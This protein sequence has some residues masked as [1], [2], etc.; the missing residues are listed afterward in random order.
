MS[1]V[2]QE[3]AALVATL[4]QVT[5]DLDASV[6][7]YVDAA[8]A[9]LGLSRSDADCLRTLLAAGSATPGQLVEA[10]GLTSGGMSGVIDR[11]ERLGFA[12]RDADPDDRR[13][14]LVRVAPDHLAA[15]S[16]LVSPWE[17]AVDD[18]GKTYDSAAL[19]LLVDSAQR[20]RAIFQQA[21]RSLGP[22]LDDATVSS[23]G[24]FSAPLDG[25]T[26][27]SLEI[28]GGSFVLQ[29]RPSPDA[30]ALFSGS[31]DDPAA[32]VSE[33]AGTV[34]VTSQSRGPGGPIS[35]TF[36]LNPRVP[37]SL[38]IGGGA[39]DVRGDLSALAVSEIAV[40]G[41][42]STVDLALGAPAQEVPVHI[43][44][45]A[46]R[47][48]L[49]PPRDIPLGVLLSGG[50]CEVRLDGQRIHLKRGTVWDAPQARPNVAGYRL[51]VRGGVSHVDIE[52]RSD[53]T[54]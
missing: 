29:L 53:A 10:T 19:T 54:A 20:R 31:L 4:R 44:G 5:A 7:K 38:R 21:T 43:A 42:A 28:R 26:A 39:H 40:T 23:S 47:L 32:R 13:R 35:G 11:L 48:A 36:D 8:A 6:S 17:S 41:G 30:T 51:R 27:A 33:S 37:W 22:S 15:L 52:P 3:N 25:V 45:G 24:V 18:A 1:T 2:E 49:R 16:V 46:T 12:Q 14:V 34:T 9:S 50:A